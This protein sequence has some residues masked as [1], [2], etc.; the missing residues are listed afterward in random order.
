MIFF[1]ILDVSLNNRPSV[2][3]LVRFFCIN[4]QNE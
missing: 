1:A 4:F 3:K 2:V